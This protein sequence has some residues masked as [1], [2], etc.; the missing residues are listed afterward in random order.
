MV[1]GRDM[2]L[3]QKQRTS[4]LI[5]VTMAVL[6]VGGLLLLGLGTLVWFLFFR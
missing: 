2:G 4:V 6:A 3:R 5:G 1:V